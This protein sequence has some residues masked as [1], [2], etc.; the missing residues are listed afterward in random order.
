MDL[1]PPLNIKVKMNLLRVRYVQLLSRNVSK[2]GM[3]HAASVETD[4]CFAEQGSGS[5]NKVNTCLSVF[6]H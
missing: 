3:Y 5:Q 2:L 6:T 4:T 1:F